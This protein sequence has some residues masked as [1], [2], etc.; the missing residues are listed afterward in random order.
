MPGCAA[1]GHSTNFIL[2]VKLPSKADEGH[3][4]M[5]GVAML[6]QLSD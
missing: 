5:R 4:I 2:Y 6:A 1:A 3:W